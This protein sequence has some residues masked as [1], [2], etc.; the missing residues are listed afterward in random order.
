MAL[1]LQHWQGCG[2]VLVV[3]DDV[4]RRAGHYENFT[5]CPPEWVYNTP[6]SPGNLTQCKSIG[7]GAGAQTCTVPGAQC[8][9]DPHAS[10]WPCDE[11]A[12]VRELLGVGP[13][14]YFG[15]TPKLGG[16]ADRSTA[17]HEQTHSS[18]SKCLLRAMHTQT[19]A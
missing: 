5:E 17:E 11:V 18:S 13:A 7:P 15:I 16:G 9:S 10:S 12:A 6:R 8:G 2:K 14:Y 4:A 1:A 19:C 3:W